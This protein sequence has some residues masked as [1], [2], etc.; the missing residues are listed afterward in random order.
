MAIHRIQ[1]L[2]NK[3]TTSVKHQKR[4]IATLL[5]DKQNE[6]AQIKVEQIIREDFTIEG[7][8][9]LEIIIS[10][11][12]ERI[13]LITNS[14]S[15]PPADLLES[16]SSIIWASKNIEIEELSS[17][18]DQFKKKYGKKFIDRIFLYTN[19]LTESQQI[20]YT[21]LSGLNGDIDTNT[22]LRSTM[23]D[24]KMNE[25]INEGGPIEINDRLFNKLS[26]RPP[27]AYLVVRYLEEIARSFNVDWKAEDELGI[28]DINTLSTV[29]PLKSMKSIG[30]SVRIAPASGITTAYIQPTVS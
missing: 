17:I 5:S 22:S 19:L 30:S 1:L 29:L 8:E 11:L 4:E 6:K 2:K 9:I 18:T 25:I 16:I 28:E 3:K 20:L 13:K 7:L 15:Y 14:K 10:L 12:S 24:E 21:K 27:S 23:I 26:Y